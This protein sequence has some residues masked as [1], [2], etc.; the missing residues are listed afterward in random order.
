[1]R[2]GSLYEAQ[3]SDTFFRKKNGLQFRHIVKKIEEKCN[4]IREAPYTACRSERLRGDLRGKRS[5]QIDRRLRLI[6]MVCE[7]CIN[8]N[9]YRHNHKDCPD[10]TKIPL[11]RIRFIDITDYH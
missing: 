1:M 3:Y 8:R 10:C 2:F 4:M 6:Y 5:G 7:E 11:K 9:D